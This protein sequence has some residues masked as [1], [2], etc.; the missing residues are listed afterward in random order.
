[1]LLSQLAAILGDKIG[2]FLKKNLLIVFLQ[3]LAVV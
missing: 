3:K 1:M 2:V